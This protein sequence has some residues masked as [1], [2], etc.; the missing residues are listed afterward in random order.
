[1]QTTEKKKGVELWAFCSQNHTSSHTHTHQKREMVIG[2]SH[3]KI[4]TSSY[5][6][7]LV[8]SNRAEELRE[9][10]ATSAAE[11]LSAGSSLK[12]REINSATRGGH[13]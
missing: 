4:S 2:I 11:G 3:I 9:P 7:L 8:S 6:H 10:F 13:P 12:H 5:H 1:M